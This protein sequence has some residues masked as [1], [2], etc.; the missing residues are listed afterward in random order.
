MT[1]EEQEK[2]EEG[3]SSTSEVASTSN[4]KTSKHGPRTCENP[5][6]GQQFIP[7]NSRA[8]YCSPSCNAK[9]SQIRRGLRPGTS[10]QVQNVPAQQSAQAPIYTPPQAGGLHGLFAIPP[11]ADMMINHYKAEA[12]RW[13]KKYDTEVSDHKVTKEK[14]EQAKEDLRNN[15][16][17]GG[18]NGFMESTAGV[19][20]IKAFAPVMAGAMS[21]RMQQQQ[22]I[23]GPAGSEMTK[24]FGE[25]TSSL[26]EESQQILWAVI[27]KL[28]N[29]DEEQMN[30]TLKGLLQSWQH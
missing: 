7:L 30:Y 9:A 2:S 21:S 25:W 10:S 13:E 3:N 4:E 8:K 28:S 6:C 17:P 20:L 29:M 5:D 18:L 23:A 15:E 27:Q 14:L 24:L 1:T 11:H 19:E 12:N 16:K 26:K 22:Q